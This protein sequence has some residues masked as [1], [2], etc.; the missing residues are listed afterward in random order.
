MKE[1]NLNELK[2]LT[3]ELAIGIQKKKSNI[4]DKIKFI[5]DGLHS[6][7]A[8]IDN[9][10]RMIYLNDEIKK[11]AKEETGVNIKEGEVCYKVLYGRN[12]VCDDC[13]VRKALETKKVIISKRCLQNTKEEL[14]ITCIP[15]IYNG[16]SGVIKIF[17][18]V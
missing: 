13:L 3:K 10:Y 18:K 16:I 7:I 1:Y 12:N 9:E 11:L 2:N 8:I 5:F 17:E 15:L 6:P 14:I 4:F